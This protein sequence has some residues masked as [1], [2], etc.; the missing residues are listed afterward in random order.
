MTPMEQIDQ[1]HKTARASF[2]PTDAHHE[3][4]Q[5]LSVCYQYRND[6]GPR[7]SIGRKVLRRWIERTRSL[8]DALK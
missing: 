5:A 3:Y 1:L 7:S 2:T 6:Y 8:R 4:V